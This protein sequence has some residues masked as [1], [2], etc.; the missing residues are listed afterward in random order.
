VNN[1]RLSN[2]ERE[3]SM[4]IEHNIEDLNVAQRSRRAF[5]KTSAQVAVTAPAVAVLLSASGKRAMAQI[6]A[7]EAS[8]SHILDDFTTGNTHEDIDALRLGTNLFSQD[9]KVP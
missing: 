5:V 6:S 9:D 8:S 1:P 2:R 4:P 3:G 7:Y